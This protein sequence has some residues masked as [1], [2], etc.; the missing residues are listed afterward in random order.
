MR[1]DFVS[2]HVYNRDPGVFRKSISYVK[3][4]L[5]QYPS[6]HPETILDEW[7]MSIGA[8]RFDPSFQP[9]F[10]A[11]VTY[12]MVQGGLDYACYYTFVIVT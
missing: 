4:T 10:V 2:W 9:C 1:L 5:S 8:T 3:E 12:E 11:E 6:L 7:N